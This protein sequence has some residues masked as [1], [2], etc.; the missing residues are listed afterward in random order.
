MFRV[1]FM[2]GYRMDSI[3]EAV[4]RL[5]AWCTEK[6]IGWHPQ[7][8]ERFEKY[9]S[10]LLKYQKRTNLIGFETVDEIVES[11]FMDSL[12][13]LCARH[14][15]ISGPVLDIGSGAG[16]PALPIKIVHP[17]VEM[18]LV[19]P[20]AKRYAFL[21]LVIRELGLEG[22]AVHRCRIESLSLDET[23]K[24][25]IS[26]ALMPFPQWLE[27]TAPWRKAGARIGCYLSENDWHIFSELAV[28]DGGGFSMT[29][30]ADRCYII[31]S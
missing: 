28:K 11:G 22:I 25:V 4:N 19:E 26:K 20:R 9:I 24:L 3:K 29:K 30:A 8:S 10:L 5:A 14:G 23:P 2:L 13:L 21:G 6:P 31:L 15:R 17:D 27:L 12:R 18:I 1:F 7:A 16:I